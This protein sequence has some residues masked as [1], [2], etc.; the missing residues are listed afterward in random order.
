MGGNNVRIMAICADD[1]WDLLI[2]HPEVGADL[3]ELSGRGRAARSRRLGDPSIRRHQ[4]GRIIAAPTTIRRSRCRP[5]RQVLPVGAGIFQWRSRRRAFADLGAIGQPFL[6]GIVLDEKRDS[7]ADVKSFLSAVRPAPCAGALSRQNDLIG[8]SDSMAVASGRGFSSRGRAIMSTARD[9]AQRTVDATFRE[10][11]IPARY[12]PSTDVL[13][14]FPMKDRNLQF[15]AP[16]SRSPRAAG[17]RFGAAEIAAPIAGGIIALLDEAGAETAR[18]R[19]VGDPTTD[20]PFRLVW[21]CTMRQAPHEPARRHHLRQRSR[22]YANAVH[23]AIAKGA[24]TAAE[25]Q[26]ARAKVLLRQDVIEGGLG[27]KIA[28]AWRA[29]I[30]PKSASSH[31]PCACVQVYSKAP[32]IVTG[33]GSDTLIQHHDGLYLALP[34]RNTPSVRQAATSPAEVEV[35]FNQDLI[36]LPGRGQAEARFRRRGEK[37]GR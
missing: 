17:S 20:D 36:F 25:R 27:D 8:I 1:F 37:Q 29:D 15:A 3:P 30:F 34:T 32:N 13:S 11:G 2:A 14:S 10:H 24:R 28:N 5:A 35:M 18:F 22:S 31:H 26:A 23:L 9:R 19:I 6:S 33:F 7:Y 12:L 21:L 4:P 16:R